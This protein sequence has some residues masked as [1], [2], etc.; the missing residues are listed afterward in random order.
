MKKINKVTIYVIAFCMIFALSLTGCGD[1]SGGTIDEPEITSDYLTEEY[2]QQLV[3][4]GAEVITGYVTISEKNSYYSISVDEQE[5]VS[6]SSYDEGYYIADT[7]LEKEASLYEDTR[8][9]DEADGELA[10]TSIE[11]FVASHTNSNSKLYSVYLMGNT[12][13]LIITV[14]P[15]NLI[16]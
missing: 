15:E 16:E 7:N 6:N 1:K 4:D 9:V 10:V 11:D 12:V 14:E 3:T 13:E 8:I 5:V 2:A